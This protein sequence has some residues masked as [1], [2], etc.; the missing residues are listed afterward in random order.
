MVLGTLANAL[1]ALGCLVVYGYIEKVTSLEGSGTIVSCFLAYYLITNRGGWQRLISPLLVLAQLYV[2]YPC[3]EMLPGSMLNL[4]EWVNENNQATYTLFILLVLQLFVTPAPDL[5][6]SYNGSDI[7]VKLKPYEREIR[8]ILMAHDYS[9]LH[10]V[11]TMLKE[12]KGYEDELLRKLKEKYGVGEGEFIYAGS[13]S[14]SPNPKLQR[15]PSEDVST[16]DWNV[17]S[18]LFQE[19]IEKVVAAHDKSLLK[20]LPEMFRDYIGREEQLLKAIYSE[21]K[22]AYVPP[23]HMRRYGSSVAPVAHSPNPQSSPFTS[24]NQAIADMALDDARKS[25]QKNLESRMSSRD[26]VW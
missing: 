11:D 18:K 2:K 6:G 13:P 26:D 22:T 14:P 20:H 10:T 24:R 19:E 23:P 5:D 25:I 3:P 7:H 17:N 8:A 9:Q 16:F 12:N 21:F 15:N 4:P 1:G